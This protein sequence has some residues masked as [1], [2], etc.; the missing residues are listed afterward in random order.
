[1]SLMPSLIR[2]S[3]PFGPA[4][5]LLGVVVFLLS[6]RAV[7]T[8]ARGNGLARSALLGQTNGI[9]FWGGASAVLGLSGTVP[10]KLRRAERDSGGPGDLTPGRRPGFRDLL[11]PHPFRPRNPDL[12]LW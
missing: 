3:G 1:M 9:L 10:G 4:L 5:V 8:A 11:P 2:L 6:V 7:W 12:F